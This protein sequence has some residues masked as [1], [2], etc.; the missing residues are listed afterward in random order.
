MLYFL[1]DSG[2][3][4][5]PSHW[6]NR[7]KNEVTIMRSKKSRS[8]ARTVS[9]IFL[10]FLLALTIATQEVRAQKFKVLHTFAGSP[11]GANPYAGLIRD[12]EG[13]LYGTASAGGSSGLG[14]VFKVDTSGTETVLYSFTGGT[15]DGCHPYGGVIQD[16]SGNLYGTTAECGASGGGTV[17]KLNTKGRLTLL[18]SF[19]GG[20]T[21]GCDALGG[22]IEDKVGNLYGT[23]AEC[24][25]SGGGTVYKL[26]TKGRL[27]LLHSFAGGASDGAL[28]IYTGLLMDNEGDLYGVTVGG[29]TSNGGV[30]YKLSRTGSLSVL[31][32]FTPTT[33]GCS[34]YGTLVM[35]KAGDLYGTTNLCGSHNGGIVW[36]VSKANRE[37][38]LYNFA[39][40]FTD[41]AN[42]FSGVVMDAKGNLYG[43]TNG[44][45]AWLSGIIYRVSKDGRLTLL[46]SL[47]GGTN[48]GFPY[49][50]LVRDAAG[51]LYGTTEEDGSDF[52]GTVFKFAP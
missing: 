6:P 23:T 52:Y 28:P 35:N 42:P 34:P 41:G 22:V 20:T 43:D 13:T 3:D 4:L 16:K 14:V 45:G 24:G 12:H 7:L 47:R 33:D 26:N 51:S 44:G 15:A 1:A 29:G 25:A 46:H 5:S 30:V 27:T 10:T 48:G 11:D 49:G 17:Y 50:G 9:T 8:A 21:D 2:V 31:H 40:G 32:S 39:G 37:T 18:H 36:R 38:V 19:A